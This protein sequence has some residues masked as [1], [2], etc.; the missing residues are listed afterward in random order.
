MK[1][2]TLKISKSNVMKRAWSIFKSGHSFYSLSFSIA[3]TRAWE[4][5]KA[6]IAYNIKKQKES[7]LFESNKNNS[8]EMR[9]NV[10]TA[11][12]RGALIAYYNRGSGVYYGD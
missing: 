3:L 10:Y 8:N 4:V 5:E 1:T 6:T 9:A 12:E 2:T 7:E 11:S